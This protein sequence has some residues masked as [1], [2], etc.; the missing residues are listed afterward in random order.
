MKE[1]RA[2]RG[3]RQPIPKRVSG[4]GS[5]TAAP[6]VRFCFVCPL[7]R[8]LGFGARERS[9]RVTV[10]RQPHR[11]L[12]RRLVYK[13][14]A[15]LTAIL[16]IAALLLPKMIAIESVAQKKLPLF[17]CKS[18]QNLLKYNQAYHKNAD[19]KRQLNIH[20]HFLWNI[21]QRSGVCR[22]KHFRP[23]D[24]SVLAALRPKE[25][26]L[27]KKRSV[28]CLPVSAVSA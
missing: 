21:G 26:F 28:N 6:F 10:R 13:P 4:D 17:S 20:D 23:I 16:I 7:G 9:E 11:Q 15:R 27:W 1:S 25:G 8:A 18:G 22:C 5:A 2:R 14:S 24:I 3:K 12:R 19:S